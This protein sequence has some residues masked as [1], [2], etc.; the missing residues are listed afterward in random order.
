MTLLPADAYLIEPL[1]GEEWPP[2]RVGPV[3][4]L[5]GCSSINVEAHHIVRRS[6]SIGPYDWV[7]IEG[8]VVGNKIPLCHH[9]HRMVTENIVR[10][11]WEEESKT[12]LWSGEDELLR[13]TQPPML[14]VIRESPEKQM[15]QAQ[16]RACPTCGHKPTPKFSSNGH[17]EKRQRKS[18]TIT[19]PAD[20]RE[21]G[22]DVL[23][24]LLESA[25]LI[26]D[27]HGLSYGHD[28]GVRYFVL[29]TALGIFVAQADEI[30]SDGEVLA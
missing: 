21:I 4:A 5:Q 12:F 9:H 29:S 17:E 15:R 7:S 18:W 10:I 2:Y 20:S 6:W 13:L 30:L 27:D 23:D 28:R 26:L 3:C 25:R 24:T 8:N 14:S 16:E 19:V 1:R 22:A 11:V